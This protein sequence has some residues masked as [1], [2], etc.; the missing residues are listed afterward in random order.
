M[1]LGYLPPQCLSLKL[2]FGSDF[3]RRF[4]VLVLYSRDYSSLSY[5]FGRRFLGHFLQNMLIFLLF[6]TF[7]REAFDVSSS[8]WRF[9]EAQPKP[10]KMDELTKVTQ[11]KALRAWIFKR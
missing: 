11:E 4:E 6:L 9:V 8:L 7:F 1:V 5:F 2:V 10:F 3:P